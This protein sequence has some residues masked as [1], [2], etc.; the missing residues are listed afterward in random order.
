MNRR[1]FIQILGSAVL[2]TAIALKIPDVLVPTTSFMEPIYKACQNANKHKHWLA[3]LQHNHA[4]KVF[5]IA[6]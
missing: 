3:Q 4:H 5:G 6:N 2:G 1:S